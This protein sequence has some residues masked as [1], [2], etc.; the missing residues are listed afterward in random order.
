M[1]VLTHKNNWI[2][3]ALGALFFLPF[4]GHVHLFDWDEINFAESSREMMI[5]GNYFQNQ[6]NFVPFWEKPPLFFWLQSLSMSTFG[7]GEFG[8][9]L[10]NALC[11]IATLL[12]LYHFGRT[13]RNERFGMIWALLYLG[14]LLPHLYFK[15]GIIDP[16][17]NLFIFCSIWMI[18][19]TTIALHK[20][21]SL[22]TSMLGGLFIGLAVITKGPVGLLIA[23]LT[24]GSMWAFLR[25]QP[26]TSIKNLLLFAGTA[27]LVSLAWFGYETLQNGPW[28]L[29]EFLAYQIELFTGE[30]GGAASGHQQPFYYH[31]VVVLTG[32]VPLSF[33]AIGSIR[34]RKEQKDN[35]LFY[36]WMVTLLAV[37]MLL[38]SIVST[39]IIHYSSMAYFP[40]SFLATVF[41][42]EFRSNMKW[43]KIWAS[44]AMGVSMLLAIGILLVPI[45]L[46]NKD[47][48]I[49]PNLND[50][51]AEA[52]L[53]TSLHLGGWEWI[54]GLIL[55]IGLILA[56]RALFLNR[57]S[58]FSWINAIGLGT[59]LLLVSATILPQIERITQA[60]LIGF[61]EE[62]VGESCYII[63]IGHKSYAHYFYAQTQPLT[64]SD[65]LSKVTE[66]FLKEMGKSSYG[67]LKGEERGAFNSKVQNWLLHG[68]IDR[69]AYFFLK[70]HHYTPEM[71][72]SAT[73]LQQNGGFVFLK[74][75]P[76]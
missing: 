54:A 61:L 19:R 62:R 3:L 17:F 7:I 6:I 33:F 8:A 21:E 56:Y 11:G 37:V 51:F 47:T 43:D 58:L 64:S 30:E 73:F 46:L 42:Y 5:T 24:V 57:H 29:G 34:K 50:P 75:E 52:G 36:Q 72:P 26:L 67:E 16:V 18:Y 49:I 60:P 65:G 32:C 9:R 41:V 25:F 71:Y 40:L 10:P 55:L 12:V 69:P 66:V 35:L 74:R 44:V 70:V 53:A 38:F 59:C 63:P 4:L 45:A 31:F 76:Q 14:T 27:L 48:W 28:F 15:S 20:R 39:K 1:N 23:L 13:L 22:I 2:L 68:N